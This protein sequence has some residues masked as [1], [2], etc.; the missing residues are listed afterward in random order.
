[1]VDLVH[2]PD[3]AGASPAPAH[4]P[5]VSHA[6]L[7]SGPP[8]QGSTEPCPAAT[9]DHLS[10]DEPPLENRS[11]AGDPA[12]AREAFARLQLEALARSSLVSVAGA[13]LS[14]PSRLLLEWAIHTVRHSLAAELG[15]RVGLRLSRQVRP[16]A[17][18]ITTQVFGLHLRILSDDVARDAFVTLDADAARTLTDALQSH[19]TGM[20]G[21]GELTDSEIGLLEFLSLV[22]LEVVARDAPSETARFELVEF[23]R[24][25]QIP[26]LIANHESTPIIFGLSCAGRS[27][28]V[29]LWAPTWEGRT[30]LK[31]PGRGELPGAAAS[32][33]PP[34]NALC[35]TLALPAIQVP[36]AQIEALGPGDVLLIGASDLES[37]GTDW[38]L[39]TTSG[40]CLGDARLQEDS[41]TCAVVECGALSPSVHMAPDSIPGHVALQPT[42]GW[43]DLPL[44]RVE[45]WERGQCLSFQK[46]GTADVRLHRAGGLAL[47]GEWVRVGQEVGVRVLSITD[48]G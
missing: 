42:M 22:T 9:E 28:S 11:T 46:V 45:N 18:P 21:V 40:W 1:M 15:Q 41:P 27:G 25:P 36:E 34:P 33:A 29:V 44:S 26:G 20:R 31:L 19:L 14:T 4:S 48:E 17:L 10:R 24:K 43:L 3:N 39:V 35:V 7:G 13:T 5:P 6:P 12:P 23:L 16:E 2:S 38:Q 37:F 30:G 32:A 8:G 47:R